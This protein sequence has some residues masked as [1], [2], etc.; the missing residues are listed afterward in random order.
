MKDFAESFY[1]S[2]RWQKC[3]RAYIAERITRDGGYCE[4]CRERLIFIVHHKIPLNAENIL[5][6]YITLSF[7]NLMGV[8]KECHDNFEGHGLKKKL[9]PLVIFDD[10]GQPIAPETGAYCTG[11]DEQRKEQHIFGD[12]L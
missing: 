10:N 7:D 12:G 2:Q 1:K 11:T 4:V 6:P 3:R 5:E 8:C 9:M